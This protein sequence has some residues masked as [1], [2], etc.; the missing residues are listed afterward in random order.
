MAVP[1]LVAG[2]LFLPV[3]NSLF[4]AGARF[5]PRDPALCHQSLIFING[6]EFPCAYTAVIRRI[7]HD[8]TPRRIAIL[9]PMNS[10]ATVFREDDRTLVITADDGWFR[11]SIDRL[12]RSAESPI[13]IGRRFRTPDFE[14][15]IRDVTNDGRPRTVAFEFDAPLEDELYRMVHW[16]RGRLESWPIPRIGGTAEL[17]ENPLFALD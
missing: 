16:R 1:L 13:E 14:A 9:A 7:E 17:E 5:A 3:F 2:L 12:M 6:H 4:T 8:P 11:H 15:T 10:S